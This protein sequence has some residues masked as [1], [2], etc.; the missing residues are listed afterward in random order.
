MAAR[1]D[2]NASEVRE[3]IEAKGA[4]DRD[5]HMADAVADED[6]DAEGEDDVDA[7]GDEDMDEQKPDNA[8]QRDQQH[9]LDLIETTSHYLCTY[10]EQ[11]ARK[12]F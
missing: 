7:E 10:R 1:R 8:D 3:S 11:Y 2:G 5:V 9:L 6:V 12:C 4:A